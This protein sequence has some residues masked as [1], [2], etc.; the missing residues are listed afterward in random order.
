[1]ISA[2]YNN[3]LHVRMH[4]LK[5]HNSCDIKSLMLPVYF[6][7]LHELIIILTKLSELPINSNSSGGLEN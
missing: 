1:M 2:D 3:G 4:H 7:G 5:R 6:K